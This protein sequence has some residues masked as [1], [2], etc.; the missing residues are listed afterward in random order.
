[1]TTCNVLDVNSVGGLCPEAKDYQAVYD[2]WYGKCEVVI[3]EPLGPEPQQQDAGDWR[4]EDAKRY[5]RIIEKTLDG[6]QW[7]FVGSQQRHTAEI[8]DLLHESQFR[9][10][11]VLVSEERRTAPCPTHLLR[12]ERSRRRRT[13]TCS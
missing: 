3:L 10:P 13:D 2:R 4:D 6:Q 8:A 11:E 9:H 7:A 12:K 5:R 1:M